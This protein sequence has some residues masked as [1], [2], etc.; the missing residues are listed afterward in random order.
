MYK[1]YGY[2]LRKED[3]E[4][5]NKIGKVLTDE[6][7][8]IFDLKSFEPDIQPEDILLIFGQHSVNQLEELLCTISKEKWLE[9][10][11]PI[12]YDLEWGDPE[13]IEIAYNEVLEFKEYL[14]N[15]PL[16]SV[17][18]DSTKQ[19]FT[20]ESLPGLTST[21]VR[22]LESTLLERG[23]LYWEGETVDGKSVRISRKPE[24]STADINLTFSEL[25]AIKIAMET[26]Q[27]TK[28]EVV[29]GNISSEK[30][31]D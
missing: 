3:Y 10:K 26:L 19:Q 17:Q 1:A 30:D 22:D 23:V 27:V 8:H 31:S 2:N 21:E 5:I 24:G 6:L 16:D 7:I 28:L 14:D 20:E 9:L 11:V 18:Q 4:I 29:C 12:R 15:R 13:D 25:Y